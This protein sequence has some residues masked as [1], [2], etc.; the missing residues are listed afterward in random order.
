[1]NS[2]LVPASSSMMRVLDSTQNRTSLPGSFPIRN[3]RPVVKRRH[4][5]LAGVA[6]A[7]V[8]DNHLDALVE[9][10]VLRRVVG[11]DRSLVAVPVSLDHLDR[12]IGVIGNEVIAH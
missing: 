3:E 2:S 12:D 4:R 7:S 5:R 10:L 9:L 1:M 8:P 11:R 6:F